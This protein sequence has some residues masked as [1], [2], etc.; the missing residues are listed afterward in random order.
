MAPVLVL[1]LVLLTVSTGQKVE[2]PPI[3][4]TAEWGGQP[5]LYTQRDTGIEQIVIHHEGGASNSGYTGAGTVR[6]IQNF[7]VGLH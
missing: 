1:V 4:T 5:P 7:H 6:S 3:L 2:K